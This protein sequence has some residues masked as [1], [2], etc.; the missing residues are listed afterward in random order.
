MAEPLSV[1]ARNVENAENCS[2]N[3]A[4]SQKQGSGLR[5]SPPARTE[6]GR[7]LRKIR[8]RRIAAGG[9]LLTVEEIDRELAERRGERHPEENS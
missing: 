1:K 2:G 3:H 6:L 5:P 8:E 7:R 4:A 9:D